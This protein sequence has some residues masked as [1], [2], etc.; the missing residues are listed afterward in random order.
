MVT[1]AFD[2]F[3]HV[4]TATEGDSDEIET[5]LVKADPVIGARVRR[6]GRHETVVLFSAKPGPRLETSYATNN[7]GGRY[8]KFEGGEKLRE[9]TPPA[10]K[11]RL[12]LHLPAPATLYL[13]DLDPTRSW[14]VPAAGATVELER[15]G[16]MFFGSVPPGRLTIV[17]S[18]KIPGEAP[19]GLYRRR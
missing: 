9:S 17:P 10:D 16:D 2:V 18:A 11:H 8:I 1:Q 6:T 5:S 14:M 7:W 13:A 4:I 19:N 3:L 12:L 15:E